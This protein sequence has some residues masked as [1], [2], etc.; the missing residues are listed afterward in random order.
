MLPA[1]RQVLAALTRRQPAARCTT[2]APQRLTHPCAN[3]HF[4]RRSSVVASDKTTA[5]SSSPAGTEIPSD[6][7]KVETV[8]EIAAREAEEA[9]W[10]KRQRITDL[11][12]IAVAAIVCIALGVP[13]YILS[14]LQE[15]WEMRERLKNSF[16]KF[17]RVFGIF[18]RDSR[19]YSRWF[20]RCHRS[21]CRRVSF[22]QYN[23]C[24]RCIRNGSVGSVPS[25][26]ETF[27][28]LP[29]G[30]SIELRIG[31]HSCSSLEHCPARN[32]D[33]CANTCCGGWNGGICESSFDSRDSVSGSQAPARR[34]PGTNPPSP[35]AAVIRYAYS[36][37]QRICRSLERAER[38]AGSAIY[39]TSATPSSILQHANG[40][41][42]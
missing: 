14:G 7:P 21:S 11:K 23:C 41:S 39:F 31:S 4:Y 29:P 24:N 27:R 18:C 12:Y 33:R 22:S 37:A 3:G 34:A 16:P 26:D 1:R 15:D 36:C 30:R 20:A 25:R 35:P 38:A 9:A 19:R 17:S 28:D 8:A 13:A 40:S 42:P 32:C 6:V 2:S 5:S 10:K